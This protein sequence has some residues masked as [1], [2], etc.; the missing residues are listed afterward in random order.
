LRGLVPTLPDVRAVIKPPPSTGV[1]AIF[2]S[3]TFDANNIQTTPT[4]VRPPMRR[5]RLLHG[6]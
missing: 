4:P 3:R 6:R 1:L 5:G 2:L